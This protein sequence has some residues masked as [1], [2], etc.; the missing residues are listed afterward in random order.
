M[1]WGAKT[2]L[3]AA[4]CQLPQ[5]RHCKWAARLRTSTPADFRLFLTSLLVLVPLPPQ[6]LLQPSSPSKP[7]L[8]PE[9]PTL[10]LHS[11]QVLVQLL[12]SCAQHC[13]VQL[14]RPAPS[15]SARCTHYAPAQN[16]CCACN[17]TF[18]QISCLQLLNQS[19]C[20][21]ESQLMRTRGNAGAKQ[22]DTSCNLP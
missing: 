22:Q 5:S 20:K 9:H 12:H 14:P 18:F 7:S 2:S 3:R 15:P 1:L 6:R 21:Q 11:Q 17:L 16:A 10:L 8:Q 13:Q 4:W 19:Y